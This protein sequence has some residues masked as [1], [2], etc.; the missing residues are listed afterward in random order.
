MRSVHTMGLS[1]LHRIT[2]V[3]LSLGFVSLVYWLLA[4]SLGEQVYAQARAHFATA[5]MRVL[6]VGWI[7]SFFYHLLNGI[8]HLVWDAGYGFDPRAARRGGYLV[9]VTALI[10]SAIV[11]IAFARR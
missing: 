6:L 8:R 7:F 2:G 5:W 1:F 10:A 3:V 9:L 4:V 11:V